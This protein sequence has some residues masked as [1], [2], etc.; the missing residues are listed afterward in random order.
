MNKIWKRTLYWTTGILLVA[1]VILLCVYWASQTVPDYYKHA[2][3]IPR[4]RQLSNAAELEETIDLVKDDLRRAEEI[5]LELTQDQING[6]LAT[7]LGS[8]GRMKLPAGVELPQ[9]VLQPDSAILAF[10]IDKENFSCVVSIK[11]NVRLSTDMQQLEFAIEEIHAGSLPV[12]IKRV[13]YELEN[14][15]NRSKIP[16]SWVPGSDRRKAIVELPADLLKDVEGP[17]SEKTITAESLE[18]K[19]ERLKVT[20][21]VDN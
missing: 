12:A 5:S 20:A 11:M 7:R 18:I 3:E 13:F 4:A 16:F 14:A 10:K 1:V 6:W 19:F 8:N 21:T 2:I 9:I 15:M 17:L